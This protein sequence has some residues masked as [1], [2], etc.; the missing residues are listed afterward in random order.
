MY[1]PHAVIYFSLFGVQVKIHPSFWVSLAVLS[2]LL[3]W[4]ETDVLG[5]SLF[6]LAGFLCIFAHEMGHAL[7][8][9]WLGA[10]R[11]EI[12]MGCT[13]GIC[14]NHVCSLS[15]T[16]LV[17]TALAGPLASLA[18]VLPVLLWLSLAYDTVG[19]AALRL[20]AMAFGVVPESVLE[21][22]PPMVVLFC[23]YVVQVSVWWSLLNLLPIFPLDGGVVMYHLLHSPRKMHAFSMA[24]AAVLATVFF[25]LGL[26]AMFCILLFLVFS[27][28]RGLKDSPY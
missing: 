3:C 2:A 11:P 20:L 16:G 15:R 24:V 6:V 12:E 27:N 10:C 26:Y 23:T 7:S 22:G 4:G 21:L 13:G 9:R 8:G 17:I 25:V 14:S 1:T 28:Y 19:A 5:M 18:M